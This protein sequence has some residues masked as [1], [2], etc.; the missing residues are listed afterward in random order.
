[1]K[2]WLKVLFISCAVVLTGACL[3]SAYAGTSRG[4]MPVFA[5]GE[6]EE[7]SEPAEAEEPVETEEPTVVEAEEDKEG[8]IKK[9]YETLVVPLLSG[10]SI[11]SILSA[12]V[13]VAMA[14]VKNKQLDKKLITISEEASEKY[15]QAQEKLK[16][17]TEILKTILEVDALVKEEKVINTEIKNC[18]TEQMAGIVDTINQNA[19]QVAKID[20]LQ[21]SVALLVQLEAK[22][23]RQSQEVVKSGIIEDINMI[24]QLMKDI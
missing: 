11:T 3:A 7:T 6:V 13:C 10:V 23:A 9:S 2:K 22:V 18:I 8:F 12:V 5:E 4:V 16:E 24:T 14:V 17:V 1:M 20:K 15:N 21:Q 19:K